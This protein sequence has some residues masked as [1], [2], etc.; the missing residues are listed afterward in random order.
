M[1]I[2]LIIGLL[3]LVVGVGPLTTLI[4]LDNFGFI[5]IPQG[6]V[7]TPGT[8]AIFFFGFLA[9]VSFPFSIP[10]ILV[11]MILTFIQKKKKKSL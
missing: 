1:H 5:E 2:V 3:I 9:M 4:L 11:G 8:E 7:E 6:P 10:I